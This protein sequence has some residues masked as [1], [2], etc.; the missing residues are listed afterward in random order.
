MHISIKLTIAAA[1]LAMLGHSGAGAKE[2]Q[3]FVPV[4]QVNFPDPFIA[5]LGWKN[6]KPVI[7]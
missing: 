3:P 5:P 4:Y 1:T 2:K 7:G 6:G